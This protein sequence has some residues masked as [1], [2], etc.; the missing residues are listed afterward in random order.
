MP[1]TYTHFKFGQDV[2][3]RLP[4]RLRRIV[5]LEEDLFDIGL[6]GPDILFY[7]HAAVANPVSLTGF[8][9]HKRNAYAFFKRSL[10]LTADEKALAYMFGFICHFVLDGQCHDYI[11]EYEKKYGVRHLEIE[12]ELD[13]SLMVTDG[14]NPFEY[15]LAG[16]VV[17]SVE[18]AEVIQRFF[19]WLSVRQVK[20]ALRD[21][22]RCHRFLSAKGA[23]K[24]V[25]LQVLFAATG[26]YRLLYGLVIKKRPSVRCVE[27]CRDLRKIYRQCVDMAVSMIEEYM[28]ARAGKRRLGKRFYRGF[29]AKK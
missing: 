11:A 1:A 15:P 17:P 4:K 19:P 22:L 28:D 7:Y 2:K 26:T 10:S 6:Y 29:D 27:S 23:M 3:Q 25:M 24:R 14:L 20:G 18:N 16:H 8:R 9:M 21:M 5:S 12:T 13:R